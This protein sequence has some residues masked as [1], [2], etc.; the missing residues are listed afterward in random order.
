[1]RGFFGGLLVGGVVV[2]GAAAILS[3]SFPLPQRPEL[4]ANTPKAG[5]DPAPTEEGSGQAPAGKDADLVELAP[6]A[7]D[8]GQTSGDDLDA[9]A[10]SDTQ[11]GDKP[12]VGEATGGLDTPQTA[13]ETDVAVNTDDPVA[14]SS[15][16]TELPAPDDQAQAPSVVEQ[17]SQPTAPSVEDSTTGFGTS[18]T[19]E[20]TAPA[21]PAP[22]QSEP[23]TATA[24]PETQ[25]PTTEDAPNPD[26]QTA[27]QPEPEAPTPEAE[28]EPPQQA[29]A[30]SE[31]SLAGTAPSP[32]I[33]TPVVPLTERDN[34]ATA[35]A[36]PDAIPPIEAYAAPFENTEDKPLMAIVLIDDADSLGL[37]ALQEFPY[38][39]SFA[40]D[41]SGP[42]A[43]EKMKTYRDAGFEVLAMT[44]LPAA[45][46]AQ[47]AEVSMSV[48][49]ETLPETVAIIEGTGSGIQ[50]NRALSDQV[51][52]IAGG[53]GRGLVTQDNGL[54]TAQ[55]LAARAGVPS[56]VVFR[57]FDGAG[58]T[59]T[60]MRR[61]L[62]Q[63]AFRAGQEGAVIMLGRVRPDTMSALLLWGLQDRASRVALAPISAVLT[64]DQGQ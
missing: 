33:G 38:P 55:K 20:D 29:E 44:D 35:Q 21:T 30:P 2:T 58:Q 41:P 10:D 16:T 5:S 46:T 15:S 13:G 43:A 36:D 8:A 47:D 53:T 9:M 19:A 32:N 45:A 54:N 64:L 59:P 26:T 6:R 3:L 40:I 4:V 52:A 63:A 28:A 42:G 23:E 56:A 24:A 57:D 14:P 11:P 37:E 7:P 60:V 48:W 34:V 1:M 39:L 25:A 18:Q 12:S 27:E 17:P 51:A 49:L 61:F 31:G 22:E 50:G 62:D